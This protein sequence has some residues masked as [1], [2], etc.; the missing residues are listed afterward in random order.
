MGPKMLLD[1][2]FLFHHWMYHTFNSWRNHHSG[3]LF[4]GANSVFLPDTGA[5]LDIRAPKP[6]H[7]RSRQGWICGGWWTSVV[8]SMKSTGT[9][10]NSNSLP[11]PDRSISLLLCNQWPQHSDIINSNYYLSIYTHHEFRK[12]LWDCLTAVP[13]CL[14]HR[15]IHKSKPR[16]IWKLILSHVL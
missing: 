3:H 11:E 1:L 8:V 2:I 10:V 14:E 7:W 16:I 5:S 9:I 15:W 4:P 13:W 6:F 12:D